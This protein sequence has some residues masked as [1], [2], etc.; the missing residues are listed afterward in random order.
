MLHLPFYD[1]EKSYEENFNQGPFGVF[2]DGQTYGQFGKSTV[3]FLGQKV[4]TPFGIAAGPLINGKF[5]ASALDHGFD[6]ATYKTVRSRKYPCHPWPNI[7]PVMVKNDLTLKQAEAGLV[8]SAEFTEPLSITNSFGVPSFNPDFWQADLSESVKKALPGQ[9]V[10]GSFQGTPTG[11]NVEDYI[12]DFSITAKLVKEAGAKILEVNLSCPNEGTAHL[13]CFD[14]ERT[15]LIV[16]AIKNEIGNTPLIIKIAYFKEENIL[17]SLIKAVGKIADGIAAINTIPAAIY[18]A[19]GA[20][21]LPGEG[22]LKSG[23]CG[24]GIRWAG[25]E[26]VAR[27]KLLREKNNL[28]YTIIGVGGVMKAQDYFEYRSVGANAVMCATG[29]MWNPYLAQEI[30]KE[31]IINI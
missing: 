19:T 5:V 13:L 30:K 6:L 26:M 7:V 22:R 21:A 11:G 4:Y 2:A 27:L 12:K 18:S 29:A 8:A 24:S 16:E 28:S 31:E 3:E 23:V 10:I 20:Q 1:P 15:R 17:E 14:I 9:V 25:L